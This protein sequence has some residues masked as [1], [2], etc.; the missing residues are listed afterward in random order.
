MSAYR[1]I[2]DPDQREAECVLMTRSRRRE[3]FR[4]PRILSIRRPDGPEVRYALAIEEPS[5]GAAQHRHAQKWE[6]PLQ[7][8]TLPN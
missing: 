5:V 7:R 4:R 3:S 6:T 2:P 8:Y 1:R